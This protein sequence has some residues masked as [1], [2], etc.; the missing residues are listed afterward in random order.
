MKMAGPERLPWHV[1][2]Q[3]EEGWYTDPYDRHEQRWFSAGKPKRLVKDDGVTSDDP[4]PT[5]PPTTFP[6]R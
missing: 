3:K 4:Q 6:K 2:D 5:G 1:M